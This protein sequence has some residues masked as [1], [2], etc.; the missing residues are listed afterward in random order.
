MKIAIS[1][2][3]GFIGT[4]LKNYLG[5]HGEIEVTGIG[6]YEFENNSV[7]KN[8]VSSSDVIV[9][10][11][12]VNRHDN[13]EELYSINI[14]LLDE[15]IKTCVVTQSS[16]YIIFSS[17]L[18]EEQDNV[19][20]KS[21]LKGQELLEK[22]STDHR[23][24][25]TGLII[26]NVFGPFGKP[27]YNSVIATFCH[28]LANAEDPKIETDKT[29][30]LIYIN[31]LVEIIWKLIQNP[32]Y[33]KIK[34]PHQF[35]Y[36]VSELLNLLKGFGHL[37]LEQ[38]EIPAINNE[39]ELALFNTFRCYLPTHLYPVRFIKNEDARGVFIEIMRNHSGGQFSFSTTKVGITRGN[40][41]HTRKVERFAVIKGEATIRIRRVDK[42]EIV[43]YALKGDEPSFVDIP[44]WHTHSI[45]NTGKEELITLFWINEPYVA[46]DADTYFLDV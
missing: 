13:P 10:L 19:Y 1:G 30:E 20:G 17:S 3:E 25:Y 7:L 40:H 5:I 15:L 8:I 31:H 28:Q 44:I 22:W 21:K 4:H 46:S 36:K 2:I 11:A 37:Y 18:Q 33:G 27:Y 42:K 34:I 12:A 43:V 41:F 45:T 29:L 23:G 6:R 38:K 14:S 26:P 24:R 16:P 32:R 9:H 39:F 35:Q